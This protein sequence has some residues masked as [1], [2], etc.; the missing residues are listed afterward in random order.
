MK[1]YTITE[2]ELNVLKN[3]AKGQTYTQDFL[4]VVNVLKAVEEREVKKEA[5]KVDEREAATNN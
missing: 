2:Q 1:T 5:K 3:S 4:N